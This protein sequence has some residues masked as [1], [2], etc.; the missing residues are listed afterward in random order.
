MGKAALLFGGRL[1]PIGLIVVVVNAVTVTDYHEG[2]P[3][4]PRHSGGGEPKAGRR[5]NRTILNENIAARHQRSRTTVFGKF[6]RLFVRSLNRRPFTGWTLDL[7]PYIEADNLYAQ[8]Q[9]DFRQRVTGTLGEIRTPALVIA[10]L[11]VNSVLRELITG[12][13]AMEFR[14]GYCEIVKLSL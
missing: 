10:H 11:G 14:Q 8:A 3:V 13:P 5:Q 1:V 12:E 6:H 2:Q 7:L 4:P 9:A